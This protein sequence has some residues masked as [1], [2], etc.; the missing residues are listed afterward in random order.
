MGYVLSLDEG[1][2]S[3]RAVIFTED[4]RTVAQSSRE[5]EQYFPRAGWVEHDPLELWS[6]SRQVIGAVLGEATLTAR[7]IACVGVTNQ[8]E[9]TVVWEAA[10]GRPVYPAIVWQD[11][12]GQEYVERLA[13]YT[14]RITELTGLYVNTYFSAIKLMWI[15]DH[16]PGARQRAERGE[17]K[18]GTIDSWLLFNLVGEHVTDVTNASRTMLMDITTG[19]W[20]RELCDL[21]GIDPQLLPRICPSMSH[22]GT[23]RSDQLLAG[24]PVTGILG[25]QQSAAFGQACFARGD[26]KSTFGTGCFLLT[27][28]GTELV[29]SHHGLVS[30]V[31]YQVDGGPLTYALEGSIAVAGS[32]V[33]WL[34]DNL[35]I[36]ASSSELETRA[37]RVDDTGGVYIV[38]AFAGLF[39]PRWRPDA[40]GTIVG[41][42]RFTNADHLCRAALESTAFQTAEVLDALGSDLGTGAPAVRVDGGMSVNDGFLQ[43]LADVLGLPVVRPHVTESTAL[44]ASFAA[45]VGAGQ[46]SVSEVAGMWREDTRFVPRMDATQ[47]NRVRREWDAAVERSL[48]WTGV[49]EH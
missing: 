38:P 23:I 34:R 15:L 29:R 19:Q 21:T 25:D 4:G 49:T 17:L 46:I 8:R 36:I 18:F 24:T 44:G 45:S 1:T 20:S 6:A 9:T 5:F 39:A 42:T 43:I 14:Q 7:D 37:S 16:I 31:A 33:H 10:T 48:G 47:R 2:T 35:G 13:P 27:N 40:R 41:L 26:T 28:T 22:V 3:T 11:T 30:T 12:R 32:L